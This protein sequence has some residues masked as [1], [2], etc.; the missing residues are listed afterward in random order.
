MKHLMIRNFLT[1]RV[2]FA[3]TVV[4]IIATTLYLGVGIN[5]ADASSRDDGD[6]PQRPAATFPANAATLGAIAD[7]AGVTQC[8]S[9]GAN[10]DVTFTVSGITGAPSNVE[11]SM[12]LTHTWVGDVTATL[13][14]PNATQKVLF[15]YTGSTTAAGCGDN[16]DLLGPYNFKDSAAAPPFGGWWQSAT[17]ATGLVALTSGDYRSTNLGGVGAVNPQPP[18]NLTAA[19]AGVA[20]SNGT[21]ILRLTDGGV[22]DTGAISA[23]TLT[24]VSAAAPP[25]ANADFNGDGKTDFIVARATN[26]PFSD[27]AADGKTEIDPE[28][29]AD[30]EVKG[31]RRHVATDPNAIPL[32]PQ[33]YWYTSIN[34]AGTTSIQP[35]GDAATDSIVT[36]DFDGDGKDDLAVWRTAPATQAAFYIFQSA[37]NTFKLQGFG[38][39]GDDP[40][41]VGDYDGDGKADPAVYRC[42][43]AAAPAGQCFFF[44][45]GSLANPSGNITYVPWGFGVAGDYYPYVG[46]FDGDGKND[47]CIQKTNPSQAGQGQFVLLKSGGGAVEYINWGNNSDFL[48]P[49][50]YDGDGKTDF[51]VRRTVAGAR[52][53]YILTRTGGTS[54]IQWGITGD[55]SVPGDYDGDGKTDLAIWRGSTTAGQSRFWVLNS[56]NNSVTQFPWG[57][58]PSGSC[59]FPVAGWL[60]H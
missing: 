58:C 2:V 6:T 11:V 53:N 25:D 32:S 7:G 56:L 8:G 45:R 24:V 30:Q 55:V 50:D 22:G 19:F 12:T 27:G 14:A 38:Q 60:V 23:A 5:T 39:T 57:Q 17:A 13:I 44:Y 1:R 46:D 31:R 37:T 33:I 4:A 9:N 35:W 54:Q 40:A 34:G 49:G 26:V 36:E 43:A 10:R 18:T 48:I 16:S 20:N 51:C 47:F 28:F 42:P 59:D 21:W 52:Q 29:I 41:V 15:G 3:A